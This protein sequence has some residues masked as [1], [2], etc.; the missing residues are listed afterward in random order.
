MKTIFRNFAY[1]LK[2]FKTSSVLNILGLSAAFTVFLV[3]MT[4]VYYDLNFDRSFKDV[5]QVY[6]MSYYSPFR[7]QHI[8]WVNTQ[9]GDNTI[10]KSSLVDAYTSVQN[11]SLIHI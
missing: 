10:S 1:V 6:L 8:C 5:D 3:L 11:L 9:L 4:Q 2:R 7:D